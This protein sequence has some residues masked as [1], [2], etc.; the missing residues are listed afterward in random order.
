M[1]NQQAAI[2]Q[3]A[4]QAAIAQPAA[5]TA[6]AADTASPGVP[7][8]VSSVALV[9]LGAVG[10]LAALSVSRRVVPTPQAD[11]IPLS[12]EDMAED[13]LRGSYEAFTRME[14]RR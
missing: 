3:P 8:W 11:A 5:L 4:A 1:P 9:A 7:S 12:D 6:A 10:T 14:L 2:A 13:E